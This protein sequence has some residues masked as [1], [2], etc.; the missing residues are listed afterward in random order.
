MKNWFLGMRYRGRINRLKEQVFPGTI[1]QDGIGNRYEV[2]TVG[3]YG[4]GMLPESVEKIPDHP[5]AMIVMHSLSA[6]AR[7][8]W[9]DIAICLEV[10][11]TPGD[12]V[13]EMLRR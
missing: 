11:R 8:S 7:A 1:L 6:T 9:L 12:S 10:V 13:E 4:V 3:R 2:K 5:L